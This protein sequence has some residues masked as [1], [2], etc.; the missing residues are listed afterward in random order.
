MKYGYNRIVVNRD[1][2]VTKYHIALLLGD[3]L[4]TPIK[5]VSSN[6]AFYQSTLP[7]FPRQRVYFFE[8]LGEEK[9]GSLVF[10]LFYL[11]VNTGDT[12]AR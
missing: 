9:K 3:F 12:G 2:H 4:C 11:K 1:V 10:L 5:N 6:Y 8:S 7:S